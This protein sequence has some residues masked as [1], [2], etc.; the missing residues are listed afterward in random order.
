MAVRGLELFSERFTEYRDAFVLIGGAACDLW[1]SD[2]NLRFRATKDLDIVLILDRLNPAFIRALEQFVDEG[3]YEYR[4]RNEDAQA[5]L[6]RFEKPADM[7]FPHMLEFFSRLPED[8]DLFPNQHIVPIRMDDAASLSAILLNNAYYYFLLNHC[9]TS[10]GVQ[11]ADGHAL[12]PLKAR[13]WLDLNDRQQNG[14]EVKGDDIRKH[15]NDVFRLAV[16]LPGDRRRNYKI[17]RTARSQRSM[18]ELS[19]KA[20]ND[21]DHIEASGLHR[22]QSRHDGYWHSGPQCHWAA[23]SENTS[24]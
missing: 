22:K 16:T 19:I 4:F 14:E 17:I 23:W 10:R 8:M 9:R 11:A 20:I 2:Q 18:P 24:S 3:Q 12:I 7:R 5:N 15:R 1:F 21:S 6:Y 13:A